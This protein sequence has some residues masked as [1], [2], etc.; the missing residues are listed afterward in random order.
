MSKI[1]FVRSN[2][3]SPD[4]R[5]EK[6]AESLGKNGHDVEVLAWDRSCNYPSFEKKNTYVIKRLKIK[7]TYGTPYLL[8]KL[9]IWTFYELFYLFKL[10]YEIIHACDFDTLIPAVLASKLRKKHL[11]YDCFD[12]YSAALPE[13]APYFLRNFVADMEIYFSKKADVVILADESRENQFKNELEE[14]VIINNAPK[15]LEYPKTYSETNDDFC[16]F[17]AGILNKTRGLDKIIEST[18]DIQNVKLIIAGYDTDDENMSEK[19]KKIEKVTFLGKLTYDEVIKQTIKCDL[20][21][22]LYDPNIPNHRYASPNKVFEAM[23]CGKPI[24]V[25]SEMGIS[26]LVEKEKFGISVPY[27]DTIAL[28]KIILKLRDNAF[29]CN[30]LGQNG[31]KIY[32]NKYNW[33]LMEEKLLKVYNYF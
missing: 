4:P 23:M 16:I 29:L 19:L 22:A 5:V 10:D 14:I 28:R 32:E 15:D 2:P 13:R 6:E 9:L 18:K 30:E 20:L 11:V 7:A 25:N 17:Y 12:F 24:I 21:F 1:L 26:D 27:T 3:V 8:F 33:M 31:R